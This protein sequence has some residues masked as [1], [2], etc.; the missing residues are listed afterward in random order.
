MKY[1]YTCSVCYQ[2]DDNFEDAT[3]AENAALEHM[4]Y[5]HSYTIEAY[6]PDGS[7]AYQCC[8]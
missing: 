3:D 4:A 6:Y 5:D 7:Y 2:E 1:K 8:T